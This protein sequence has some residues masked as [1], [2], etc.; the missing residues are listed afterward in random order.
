MSLRDVIWLYRDRYVNGDP[1]QKR[2]WLEKGRHALKRYLRLL[3]FAIYLRYR[4]ETALGT[5]HSP[6]HNDH[7]FC[8]DVNSRK[9]IQKLP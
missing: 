3:C 9:P 5:L 2:H 6:L 1:A 7:V 4:A 8:P